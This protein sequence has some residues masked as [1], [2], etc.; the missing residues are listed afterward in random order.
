[1][2]VEEVE[3]FIEDCIA[4]AVRSQRAGFDGV[5]LHGAHGYLLAQFLSPQFNRRD[6]AYGG[7]PEKRAKV[8]FDIIAGINQAC[9]REFSWVSAYHP[10]ALVSG[11]RK[12][13]TRIGALVD[14]RLDYLDMSLWDVFKDAHDEAFA[15]QSLLKVFADLPRKGSH[16]VQ[17]VSCIR[18]R[19]ASEPSRVAW[20]LCS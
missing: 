20:T 11:Q 5:Q 18:R 12:Y 16:W 2:T 19:L 3:G 15:G 14:P 13:A 7:S 10:S 1:M 9:G 8:L 4:A 6:D 17:R